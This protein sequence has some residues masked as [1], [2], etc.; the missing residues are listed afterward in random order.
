[1]KPRTV[2]DSWKSLWGDAVSECEDLGAIDEDVMDAVHNDKELGGEGFSDMIKDGIREHTENCLEPF[3]NE[4]LEEL[5]QSP[6]GNDDEDD[7][8]EN[9]ETQTPLDWTLLKLASIFRQAQVQKDMIA[10]YD[11]SMEHGIMVIRRITFSLK[12]L[13]ALFDETKKRERQSL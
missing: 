1:M 9:R 13:H 6:K 5:M 8:I 2:S 11:P 4:E 7:V 10:D 3:T 12:P